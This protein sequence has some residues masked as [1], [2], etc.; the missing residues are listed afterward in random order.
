[1]RWALLD[2]LAEDEVRQVISQSRRRRFGQREVVFHQ[3]DPADS[4]H[5]IAKGHF[6]VRAMTPL[7]EAA[8]FTVLAPG[9]FFGELAL[10]SPQTVRTATVAALEDAETYAITAGDLRR[11]R[12]EHPGITESLIGTLVEE[13]MR[14]SD[15]VVEALYVPAG[16]R[17]LRR[18]R[19]LAGT[20]AG[21]GADVTIP[22]TQEELA[23]LAGT[24]RATVNGVLR[25]QERRGAISLA[26][27]KV[28]I[29]DPDALR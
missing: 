15:R 13:V 12:R 20:Y 4:L 25:E 2:G 7:G 11:L 9:G 28:R 29:L 23:E 14:L 6:A 1:M 18:L 3:G 8:T 5:L 21:D 27:R 16:E 19:E 17:V 22:L 24:S 10:L 26:R